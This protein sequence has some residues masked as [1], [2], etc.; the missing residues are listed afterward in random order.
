MKRFS[1]HSTVKMSIDLS[2]ILAKREQEQKGK[3]IYVVSKSRSPPR[4]KSKEKLLSKSKNMKSPAA[5]VVNI[6]KKNPYV[7][8]LGNSDKVKELL[9][10][11]KQT[12]DTVQTL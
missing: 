8:K 7:T 1:N 3:R 9:S 5:I 6:E 4:Q 12:E 2:K 11:L 10:K